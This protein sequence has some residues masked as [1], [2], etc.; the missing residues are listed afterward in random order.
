[1]L[2]NIIKDIDKELSGVLVKAPEMR[3][4]ERISPVLAEGIRDF[5]KRPGKRIR[6]ALFTAGYLG[7]SDHPGKYYAKAV[8][9]SLSQE[10]LHA[11]L[12]IHDD[13]IDN[14][15]LR[16]GKPSLHGLF[17]RALS[18]KKDNKTGCDL[19]IVAGDIIFALAV[20][21]LNSMDEDP[22]R[23]Q[24]AME[25]F[26]SSAVMTGAGEFLDVVNDIKP[27]DKLTEKDIYNTYI[28]KTAKYTFEFPLVTG[29]TLAGAPGTEIKKLSN[30]G[31]LLGQAFQILDDMLDIF[32]TSKRSGKPVLSD[33]AEGKK[34]LIVLKTYTLLKSREKILFRK[35]FE[36]KYKKKTGLIE[37]KDLIEKTEAKNICLKKVSS[38]LSRSMAI[39]NSLE[40]RKKYKTAIY[41]IIQ[42]LNKDLKEF[43]IKN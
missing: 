25:L 6:P 35:L 28:L 24:K 36:K 3:Y 23:K 33:I 29:A 26:T 2:D 4:L 12:L 42:K 16:R 39:Y 5:V 43:E 41:E 10:L 17:N 40:M 1:M 22:D 32:S 21:N 19:G 18:L 37:I 14:S 34:T 8:K 15:D 30:L 38:F 13:I 9:A 11:F 31:I 27:L 20:K 7:Y